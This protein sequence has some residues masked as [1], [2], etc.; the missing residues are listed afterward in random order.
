MNKEVNVRS[1]GG[2]SGAMMLWTVISGSHEGSLQ[3]ELCWLVRLRALVG[4]LTPAHVRLGSVPQRAERP[5][6]MQ[7]HSY[8]CGNTICATQYIVMW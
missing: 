8:S 1:P 6:L 4:T 7:S 5:R 3:P 2:S